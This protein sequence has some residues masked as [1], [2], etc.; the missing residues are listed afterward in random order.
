MP[1]SRILGGSSKRAT[2]SRAAGCLRSSRCRTECPAGFRGAARPVRSIP[3]K[4]KLRSVRVH[5]KK[6]YDFSPARR[7]ALLQTAALGALALGP[8]WVRAE[9]GSA[10]ASGSAEFVEVDTVEG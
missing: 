2:H 8:S 4:T 1:R 9:S 10:S 7:S 3:A 6:V 5:V